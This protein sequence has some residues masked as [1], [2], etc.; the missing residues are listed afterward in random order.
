MI[1]DR[2]SK[3]GD[4]HHRGYIVLV[5]VPRVARDGRVPRLPGN[6]TLILHTQ[7]NLRYEIV[8]PE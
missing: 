5:T 6:D 7:A 3:H 2:E 8:D 1:Q 4:A